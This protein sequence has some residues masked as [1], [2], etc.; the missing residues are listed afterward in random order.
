MAGVV[1]AKGGSWLRRETILSII[2]AL[3]LVFVA[4]VDLRLSGWLAAIYLIVFSAY[5]L[6][7]RKRKPARRSQKVSS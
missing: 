6:I 2:V 3:L 7:V 4:F 5:R 1:A